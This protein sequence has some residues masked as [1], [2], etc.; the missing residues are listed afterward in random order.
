MAV[1]HF[2][3]VDPGSGSLLFQLLISGLVGFIAFIKIYWSK[4]KS[5]FSKNKKD[6]LQ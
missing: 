2:L 6:G 5:Y 3:Y 1:A 4:I